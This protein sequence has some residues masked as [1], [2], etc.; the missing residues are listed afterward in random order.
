VFK[1]IENYADSNAK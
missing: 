1:A